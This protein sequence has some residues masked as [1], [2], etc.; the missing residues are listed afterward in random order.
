MSDLTDEMW[1]EDD[2]SD[3]ILDADAEI[4][5][6][7]AEIA[8]LREALEFGWAVAGYKITDAVAVDKPHKFGAYIAETLAEKDAEI[9]ALRDRLQSIWQYGADTLS[10]NA[11]GPNNAAFYRESVVT[12]TKRADLDDY[13]A[14]PCHFDPGR[15][16]PANAAALVEKDAEI[17]A[18][19]AEVERLTTLLAIADASIEELSDMSEG[20]WYDAVRKITDKWEA[21]RGEGK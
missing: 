5:I 12:M 7:D 21:L 4:D 9:A 13:Y 18:L 2:F 10:G 3:E 14:K 8:T 11:I 16:R 19:K 1:H 20:Y 6:R 15:A 17:A